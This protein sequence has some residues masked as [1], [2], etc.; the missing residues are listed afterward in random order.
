M[1]LEKQSS[2]LSDIPPFLLTPSFH[3]FIHF[4]GLAPLPQIDI[5][6][7]SDS[8]SINPNSRGV[9]PVAII[10]TEGFDATSVNASSVKFGPN[11]AAEIHKRSH[12]EDVNG[13]GHMDLMLHFKTEEI[14]VGCGDNSLTLTGH[15]FDGLEIIGFDFIETVGCKG[16]GR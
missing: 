9:I 8:N 4:S 15:T 11:E 7:G 5:K 10:T 3:K 2:P 16:K 14:G 13:D 1:E 12:I 6:P